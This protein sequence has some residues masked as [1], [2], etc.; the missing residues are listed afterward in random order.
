MQR[1]QGHQG[2]QQECT[3]QGPE[4]ALETLVH[5]LREQLKFQAAVAC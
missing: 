5:E 3:R 2:K 1:N 4:V